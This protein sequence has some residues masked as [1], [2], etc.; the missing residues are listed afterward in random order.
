MA[1]VDSESAADYSSS[2]PSS[3]LV[4]DAISFVLPCGPSAIVGLEYLRS[5]EGMGRAE[6]EIR[7]RK[8]DLRH[9]EG[10]LYNTQSELQQLLRA[11]VARRVRLNGLWDESASLSENHL[12]KHVGCVAKPAHSNPIAVTVRFL[13]DGGDG[14]DKKDQH[15]QWNNN[16]QSKFKLM[17]VFSC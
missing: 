15:R 11:P 13:R 17:S 12:E 4:G 8:S 10:A 6:V 7:F 1:V 16:N 9:R 14:H 5:Y 3:S 2:S